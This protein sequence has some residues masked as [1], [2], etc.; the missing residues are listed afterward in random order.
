MQLP[1]LAMRETI[2]LPG[3]MTVF[4]VGR[5]ASVSA[6]REA[7]AGDKRIF[8]VAQR[9]AAVEHP[10][11][12]D[13]FRVGTIA[14][15][16]ESIG[17]PDGNVRLLVEGMQRAELLSVTDDDGLLR[18]T[19]RVPAPA[20]DTGALPLAQIAR[21]VKWGRPGEEESGWR[22]IGLEDPG[23]L[24]DLVGEKK[25]SFAEKQEIL[26]IF[27]PL[28]RLARLSTMLIGGSHN[29]S[30][31]MAVLMRWAESCAAMDRLG[32]M[33]REEMAAR[34]RSTRVRD[35]NER[36]RRLARHLAEELAIYGAGTP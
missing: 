8:L 20:V 3:T 34:N 4:V 32:E 16:V 24:A 7:I 10:K 2:V 15:I 30:I 17:L 23:K 19:V 22:K 26:E 11:A 27:D 31:S 25:L 1:L 5:T 14:Y 18:A 21:L 6:L 12:D 9:D 13:L 35:L 28:E 33:V 36:S 29:V